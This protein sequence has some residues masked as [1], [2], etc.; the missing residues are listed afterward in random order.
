MSGSR[1]TAAALRG[2]RAWPLALA[3]LAAAWLWVL[4]PAGAQTDLGGQRVGTSSGSFLKIGL[5]ARGS[6]MG[7]AVCAYVTGPAALLWNPA[8]L[9]IEGE[10]SVLLCG[11]D[12]TAGIPIG[13]AVACLPFAP[14]RGAI[15]VGLAGL[16]AT[17][18]ETDEFHPLGT[19][20]EF[21]YS[22][23]T[24]TF[25]ASRALTDK[26][27]F[28][29]AAKVFHESFAPELDG[30]ELTTWLIDAGAIYFVG[31]RDTRMGIIL[32]NFGPDLRPSGEF[33]SHRS[34]AEIRYTSFS[35]PTF[36]RFGFSIDPY[37]SERWKL[38]TS[39]EVGHPA[40]N[41]EVLRAGAELTMERAFAVRAGYD[42]SA[43]ALKLHAGCGVRMRF[44]NTRIEVD[45]AYADGGYF[46]SIHRWGV[47]YVW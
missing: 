2:S 19:G 16:S 24:A 1:T 18:D 30:T 15:G 28:G 45:Y 44:G 21:T 42:F 14:I 27:S 43:D 3:C 12:Y 20:R 25:G 10:R 41:R 4:A 17:M 31:Y 37:Q 38:V 13:A 5:D 26:L 9:G 35:P 34:A 7:G 46:G 32:S 39:I 22:T 8:G 29:V 33:Q 11:V 47:H 6:A 36:F 40:D 23:W